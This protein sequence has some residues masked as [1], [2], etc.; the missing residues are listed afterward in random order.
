MSQPESPKQV[1]SPPPELPAV[2]RPPNSKVS[3][4][5][6]SEPRI[7]SWLLLGAVFLIIT[8]YFAVTKLSE[9]A[10]DRSLVLSGEQVEAVIT[11]V[12][13][14]TLPQRKAWD[15][16]LRIEFVVASGEKISANRSLSDKPEDGLVK[17]GDVVKIRY[18][19]NNPQR[20]TDRKTPPGFA[21]ALVAVY[22]MGAVTVAM[23]LI[24]ALQRS[25]LLKTWRDGK[26]APA[27][28]LSVTAS[29]IAPN[30]AHVN[31]SQTGQQP[32]A[33]YIPKSLGTPVKGDVL[34]LLTT[35]GGLP[36]AARVFL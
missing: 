21:H 17:V 7:R 34:W 1:I 28:V 15:L 11:E 31:V 35:P 32:V 36:V 22:I 14:S 13:G 16:P 6:W 19:K 23:A 3:A 18:D 4:L 9:W 2:P 29:P 33:V 26:L 27:A 10:S 25:R 20:W 5:G 12:N 24:A 30:Y 8:L